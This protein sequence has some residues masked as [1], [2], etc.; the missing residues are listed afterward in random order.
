MLLTAMNLTDHIRQL[1]RR[2]HY[3]AKVADLDAAILRLR[4]EQ[5]DELDVHAAIG[6]GFLAFP[7]SA[8]T[9]ALAELIRARVNGHAA[10]GDAPLPVS[11]PFP[12]IA[13]R[14]LAS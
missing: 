9:T 10:P 11:D 8:R 6:L 4:L 12:T 7:E 13:T 5:H 2:A 3:G 14:R 1:F